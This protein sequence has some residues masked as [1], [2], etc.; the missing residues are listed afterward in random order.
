MKVLI[1]TTAIPSKY[2]TGA[3]I[4][5]RH[6]IEAIK[7]LGHSVSV[8]G[9]QR[10]GDPYA[11]EKDMIVVG[12][13]HIETKSARWHPIVWAI[14]GFLRQLPYTS[15]KYYSVRYLDTVK[16]LLAEQHYDAIVLEHSSQLCWLRKEIEQSHKL[17]V[18]AHNIEHAIFKERIPE[19]KKTLMRWMYQRESQLTQK[20]EDYLANTSASVWTLS[21][22]DARYFNDLNQ[23]R[24]VKVFGLP[25]TIT[26]VAEPLATKTFDIGM[27]GSW[28]W[29]PNQDGL[30]WF[31]E[32][33]Y[34]YLPDTLSIQVAGRGADWLR[35]RY[36][37]V[38]YHGFV[39]NAQQFLAQARVIPLPSVRGSG[40]QIKTLEAI[41]QGLPIVATP[42]A[43]RNI[44][45]PPSTVR[46]AETPADFASALED[47]IAISPSPKDLES[48]HKWLSDRRTH[49]LQDVEVALSALL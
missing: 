43:L 28:M 39:E 24:S 14:N 37:N 3:D 6:F 49:F 38:K 13:R 34:P 15:A 25:A 26:Q 10:W 4:A 18:L 12:Q 33:V 1:L 2:G 19:T 20:M 47:A 31:F 11:I 36:A 5:S 17:A 9:Y 29:K 7:T 22:E 27:I 23:V 48:V 42:L 35:N 40:V 21:Q 16:K 30:R 32:E 46:Q 41:G 44:T 8:V 45:N